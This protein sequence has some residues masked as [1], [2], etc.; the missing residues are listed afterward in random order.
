MASDFDWMQY[1]TLAQ[2]LAGRTPTKLA[3]EEAKL[4]CAISRIYYAVHWTTRIYLKAKHDF[5]PPKSAAHGDLWRE[6]YKGPPDY[7]DDYIQLGSWLETLY[8][9]RIKA[10]YNSK[11]VI[12]QD[13][14]TRASDF[15]Q[16]ILDAI[17]EFK[18]R[19]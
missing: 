14:F 10:D 3:D 8:N 12:T 19:P 1:Y 6:L 18:K 5:E 11:A 2:E 4:R 9:L 17:E 7:P 15:A 13:T 16:K